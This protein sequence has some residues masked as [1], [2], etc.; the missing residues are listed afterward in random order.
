MSEVNTTTS[1]NAKE[2]FEICIDQNQKMKFPTLASSQLTSTDELCEWANSIFK[3]VFADYKG[4]VV[5]YNA[6]TGRLYM[7]L[8]FYQIDSIADGELRAFEPVGGAIK[9]ENNSGLRRIQALD[10]IVAN[11]NKFVITDAA[12]SAIAKFVTKDNRGEVNWNALNLITQHFESDGY[13]GIT[14]NV[15]NLIDP[16]TVMREL[17]GTKINAY[18]GNDENGTPVFEEHEADYEII[19]LRA[20]GFANQLMMSG[21]STPEEGPFEIDVRQIDKEQL[22][23][24][25]KRLGITNSWGKR[26]IEKTH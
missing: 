7:S 25:Q 17:F 26:I 24:S 6:N 4:S 14:Y 22:I 19:V 2:E 12:K 20:L 10:R 1:E 5:K 15:I 11:G 23:A 9:A 21:Q 16:R 18:V 13:K 8:Y 3:P